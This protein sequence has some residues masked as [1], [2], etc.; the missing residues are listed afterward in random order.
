MGLVVQGAPKC[1][2]P[3]EVAPNCFPDYWAGRP[4]LAQQEG[5]NVCLVDHLHDGAGLRVEEVI[6]N[7]ECDARSLDLTGPN[8]VS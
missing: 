4:W 7:I 6:R 5:V 2:G 1:M 3:L 8:V